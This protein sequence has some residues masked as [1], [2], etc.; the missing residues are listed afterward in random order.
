VNIVRR[1]A[2]ASRPC[3]RYAVALHASLDPDASPRRAHEPPEKIK[4]T[5]S[6]LVDTTPLLQE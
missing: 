3:G 6:T 1:T 5:V 4:N 2:P